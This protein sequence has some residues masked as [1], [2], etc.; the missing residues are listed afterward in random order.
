[1]LRKKYRIFLVIILVAS[2]FSV[3]LFSNSVKYDSTIEN[4]DDTIDLYDLRVSGP[5]INI[6]TPENKTYTGPM[7][8]YYYGT[9]GFESDATGTF[10]SYFTDDS[11][12][13]CKAEII[14]SRDGH[15]KVFWFDDNEFSYKAS[16]NN[17]FNNQTYGTVEYWVQSNDVTDRYFVSL[18][19]IDEGI[20]A[21]L[22]LRDDS[23]RDASNNIVQK[24]SG[25]NMDTPIDN[26]WYHVRMDFE[27]TTGGYMGLNQYEW[28]IW[29]DGV[30]SVAMPFFTDTSNVN[31]ISLQ[32]STASSSYD[33]YVDAIGYSWDSHYNIGDNLNEGIVLNFDTS[34]TSDW[35][36]YSLDGQSN[37]TILGNTTFPLLPEGIHTIQ[38][39]GNDSLGTNYQS[40]IRH[41]SIRNINLISP[42]NKTYTG[43]MSGYYY[44]TYGFESDATGTFPSYFTDDST[45]SC[46]AEII[47]SRDGHKKVFWFD[48]NEFS[49]KA[50]VN[51][52]FN[53]QTYGTVEYWVQ[54]NDVTDRYFVSLQNIDEGISAQLV[55][56]DDSWR[57]ASNNIVQKASGGNMDTPIDNQWYHVRMDFECTTGGYM[58]L[59]QYEWK[60]WIDGVESVAMPFFTDTSNVNWISLQTSTASS[61]Y[62]CYVDVIGYS[63]DPNYNIGDNLDEGLLVSFDLGFS[64]DWLGYSLD[65]QTNKTILGN[66]TIPFPSE[67]FHTIQVFGNDSL[68][69]IYESEIRY[70]SIDLPPII[71]INK[72]NQND[73]FGLIAPSYNISIIESYL[74]ETW[75]TLDNGITNITLTGLTGIINQTEWDKCIEGPITIRFYA[76]DS[77]GNVGFEDIIVLKD[78]SAPIITINT[79]DENEFYAGTPPN[80]DITIDEL[81]LNI[82]WYTLDNG[83][84]NFTFIG[85]TGSINQTEWDK[86]GEGPVILRF[87]A[88][89]SF[90][91]QNYSEITIH[92]DITDPVLTIYSP[93]TGNRFTILPPAFN[94]EVNETNLESIWYTIDG[95]LNN[96]DITQLT[97]YIDST[98]WNAA[99][100]GAITIRFYAEDKAGN[101]VY[102]DIVVQKRSPPT[103]LDF[104]LVIIIATIISIIGI[105]VVGGLVY[106]RKHVRI[107]K[108]KPIV[109]KVEKTEEKETKRKR[110]RREKI[111]EPQI[112]N[113]PFCHSEITSDQEYCKFCG[114]NLRKQN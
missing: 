71:I 45:S 64:P 113:C 78:T 18:Q 26:Q 84:N 21:Q 36:G 105:I 11:T 107:R 33:C 40:D 17:Y 99:P 76:N 44:G 47:A 54:S 37:R 70:F 22:V 72:P 58:G 41:F 57:D 101:V 42:E 4:I 50:S 49:Y 46:K 53:N 102:T 7:S 67:G 97:G 66:T 38:L 92:K 69:A 88:N 9:Y 16:V 62:D 51:N 6:T 19:N 109:K 85:L 68:N 56:R 83:V 52:Y 81:S 3:I 96:Y 28:K 8:G 104:N 14:A 75:Y 111:I 65:S 90:G 29:I 15:K 60:I 23:W 80:F 5:Q 35:L 12:S 93:I 63:W 2:V 82:T 1:M 86:Q 95:G 61:S 13:S 89:D 110:R 112:I 48:D 10:P 24:A 43:P 114:G 87:Y 74:N 103:P 91:Y 55:L 27:C 94:I 98:A 32:T 25:G 106:R 73:I 39:F 100:T 34:F 20:S 77:A 108:P 59:N 79:P 31:W 30:E